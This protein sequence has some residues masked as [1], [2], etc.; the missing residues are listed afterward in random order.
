M[1]DGNY[2]YALCANENYEGCIYVQMSSSAK[3]MFEMLHPAFNKM[4]GTTN[5]LIANTEIVAF[6]IHVKNSII[7][8]KIAV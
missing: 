1:I 3:R 2:A 4:H 8:H 6:F 7:F 5:R